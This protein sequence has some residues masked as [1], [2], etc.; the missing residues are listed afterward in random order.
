MLSSLLTLLFLSACAIYALLDLQMIRGL[1]KLKKKRVS[2]PDDTP[3]LSLLI[4]ARNEEQTL[5][6]VLD[7]LLAQDYPADKVRIIVI[8]DRSSDGTEGVLQRY[9]AKHP[10]RI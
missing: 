4:A 6:F 3:S 2:E 1:Q 10:D 8:N 9:A 7:D 5:P